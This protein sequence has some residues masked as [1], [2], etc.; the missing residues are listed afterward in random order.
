M[1]ERHDNLSKTLK[2]YFPTYLA[3]IVD[4]HIGKERRDVAAMT[5]YGRR[6][7]LSLEGGFFPPAK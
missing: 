6:P 3:G 4:L 1:I 5:C 7:P 2:T